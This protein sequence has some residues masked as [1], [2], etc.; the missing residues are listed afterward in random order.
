M[1]TEPHYTLFSCDCR[2]LASLTKKSDERLTLYLHDFQ[3]MCRRVIRKKPIRRGVD[4][5]LS[6][7]LAKLSLSLL[8]P[9]L[10]CHF[11]CVLVGLTG[12]RVEPVIEERAIRCLQRIELLSSVRL[13]V[14]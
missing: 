3:Q 14:K 7:Y 1:H 12:I 4:T 8:P 10:L 13:E 6:L 5:L 11:L 9:V 2:Q